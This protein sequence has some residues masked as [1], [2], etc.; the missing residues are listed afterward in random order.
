MS[1]GAIIIL[2]LLF[3]TYAGYPAVIGLLA[4][5]TRRQPAAHRQ[6]RSCPSSAS[7]CP[8]STAAR[9]SRPK[10]DSLLAQDYPADRYRDPDHRDGLHG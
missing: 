1:A 10:L 9:T 5:R 3:F 8:C 6:T 2:A 4:A 7:A